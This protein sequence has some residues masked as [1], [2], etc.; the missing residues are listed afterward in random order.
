[1]EFKVIRDEE[2]FLAEREAWTKLY[3]KATEQGEATPFQS[4]EWCYYWWKYRE[5]RDSLFI[6]KAYTGKIIEGYAPL[7]VKN[8]MVEYIGGRDMDYGRFLIAYDYMRAIRGFIDTIRQENFGISFQEMASNNTQLHIVQKILENSKYYISHRTTRTSYIPIYKFETFD[9]YLNTLSGKFRKSLRKALNA[10]I[11]FQK[12]N[13]TESLLEV[14]SEI[15][16]DRQEVRGGSMDLSWAIP[17]IKELCRCGLLEIYLGYHNGCPIAYHITLCDKSAKYLW[18]IAHRRDAEQIRPGRIMRY[19][20]IQKCFNM[21]LKYFNN[22]RGDYDYKLEWNVELDTNYTIFV[23]RNP[24]TY[25]KSRI[26]FWLRP[27]LKKIVYS[28]Q[29]L[30][31]VYKKYA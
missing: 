12:E 6:I 30:K 5:E 21:N 13:V 4:W 8:K 31:K 28:N 29:W 1:M 2:G 24:V 10:D 9:A 3:Q 11:I 20:L 16:A 17:M 7:V 25:I 26:C 18:L 23:Y 27:K 19:N 15:F 22:M 14:I